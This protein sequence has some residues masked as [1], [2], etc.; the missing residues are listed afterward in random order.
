VHDALS[1]F[2]RD[3]QSRYQLLAGDRAR[4]LLP[5]AEVF[6]STED[7]FVLAKN[8]TRAEIAAAPGAPSAQPL[9]EL[10]VERRAADPL[11][12]LKA[13]LAVTPA[14]VMLLAESPGRRETLAQ[15]LAEYGLRPE[16]APGFEEFRRSPARLAL[17]VAP[18]LAGGAPRQVD[19]RRRRAVAGEPL[20]EGGEA[21][22]RLPLDPVAEAPGRPGDAPQG[23]PGRPGAHQ[24]LTPPASCGFSAG[25]CSAP[26]GAVLPLAGAA[27]LPPLPAAVL[28]LVEAQAE[29]RTAPP[30]TS[31]RQSFEVRRRGAAS[32]SLSRSMVA[33]SGGRL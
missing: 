19:Q 26:V 31:T 30:T 27:A 11:H 13:F 23:A 7:F 25:F 16:P 8:L 14:R 17:G 24:P 2:R 32:F 4:P 20:G 22:L 15:Y 33:I 6:L 21:E 5:P 12:R 28:S 3:A 29:A 9:P 10:A 18:L 1:E